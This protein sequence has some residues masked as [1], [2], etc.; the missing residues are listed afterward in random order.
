M[1]GT[2]G[3]NRDTFYQQVV[4]AGLSKTSYYNN[5]NTTEQLVI[6]NMA[7]KLKANGKKITNPETCQ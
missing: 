4:R 6:S 1:L 5:L 2:T 3:Y 7:S